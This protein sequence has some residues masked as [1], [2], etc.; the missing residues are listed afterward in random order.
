MDSDKRLKPCIANNRNDRIQD[1]RFSNLPDELLIRILSLLPTKDAAAACTLSNGLRHVLPK[2]TALDIDTSPISF[3]LKCPDRIEQFPFFVT[4]V[5]T[6]LQAHQ[7][8]YLTKFRLKVGVDFRERHYQGCNPRRGGCP[9]SCYPELTP[10]QINKWIT[11]PLTYVGLRELEL[12]IPVKEPGDSHQL[13]SE[14]FTCETLEVLK[15]DVDLRF[16]QASTLPSL[17]LPNLKVLELFAYLNSDDG[18][19]WRLISSCPILE[20]LTVI[21]HWN[22]LQYINVSSPS[23]RRLH[24][25]MCRDDDCDDPPN[26]DLVLINTP[27][28]EHISYL[29]VLALGYSISNM[30]FL[31]TAKI[32]PKRVLKNESH[33]VSRQ[34]FLKLIRPLSHVQHLVLRGSSSMLLGFVEVMDHLPVFQNLKHLELDYTLNYWDKVLLAFLKCSPVLETLA[35][36]QGLVSFAVPES[37]YCEPLDCEISQTTIPPCC[38]NYLKRIIVE[39]CVGNKREIDLVQFLLR[40]ALVLEKLIMFRIQQFAVVD[41]VVLENILQNLPRASITCSIEV[42]DLTF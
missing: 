26:T 20:D 25:N 5:D 33:E 29:D 40:H 38:R 7:S 9:R 39:L 34:Q 12:C 37:Y 28:L 6:V 11:F 41:R 42:Q 19:L 35:F 3:C 2:I 21:A 1:D 23:L 32:H 4:F 16:D 17:S 10:I 27:N 36:P 31:I 18:F 14:I 15:L 24:I 8:Q 30:E 22:R 13:P